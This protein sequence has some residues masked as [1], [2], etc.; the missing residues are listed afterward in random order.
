MVEEEVLVLVWEEPDALCC[1]LCFMS[2][3]AEVAEGEGEAVVAPKPE[4]PVVEPDWEAAGVE[5]DGSGLGGLV[6]G[7]CCWV[8]AGREVV[9]WGAWPIPKIK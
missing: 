2:W 4:V 8:W 9:C 5:A 6:K 1:C 3:R 7:S